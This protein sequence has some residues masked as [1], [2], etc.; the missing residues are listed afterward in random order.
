MWEQLRRT[1]L[2]RAKQKLA[3]LRNITLRRH[4]EE[5]KQIDAED[6][7][8]ETLER[9]ISALKNKYLNPGLTSSQS[10]TATDEKPNRAAPAEESRF[11]EARP[12]TSST[13]IQ[14]Q[15]SPNFGIPLRKF[16]R[17]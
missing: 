1:D 14:P 9:M 6:A 16:V 10:I 11:P 15:A 2:E 4:E 12:Y 5:L 13:E 17:R 7:E 8:I 3:E